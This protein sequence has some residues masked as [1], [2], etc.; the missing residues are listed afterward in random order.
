[1]RSVASGSA[2]NLTASFTKIGP[3]RSQVKTMV[4]V[5]FILFC[6]VLTVSSLNVVFLMNSM[7]EKITSVKWQKSS[8]FYSRFFLMFS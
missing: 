4:C 2:A 8:V 7:F 5:G 6:F 3:V 1:M